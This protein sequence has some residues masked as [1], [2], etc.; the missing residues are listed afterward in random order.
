MP[1]YLCVVEVMYSQGV[2]D[3]VLHTTKRADVISFIQSFRAYCRDVGDARGYET[4]EFI[5]CLRDDGVTADK[6]WSSHRFQEK[7][8]WAF[9]L[10]R[11]GQSMGPQ[12]EGAE[13]MRFKKNNIPEV[14]WV[15]NNVEMTKARF[16]QDHLRTTH[17]SIH[18]EI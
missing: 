4:F 3:Y 16:T 2:G 14:G 17:E 5:Y 8:T 6:I 10:V 12:K 13:V 7:P 15:F 1:T 11:L 18:R 9:R